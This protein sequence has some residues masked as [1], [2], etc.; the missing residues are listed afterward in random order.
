MERVLDPISTYPEFC[1]CSIDF[2]N[3]RTYFHGYV[4]M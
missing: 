2:P 3:V 4:S 1:S